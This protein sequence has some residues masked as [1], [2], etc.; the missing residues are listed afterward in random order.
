MSE[1]NKVKIRNIKSGAMDEYRIGGSSSD[2]VGATSSQKGEHGLVPAPKAG[3]QNKF[4]RGD[5]SWV[6]VSGGEGAVASVNGM[7]GTV[8]LGPS[9]VNAIPSDSKGTANGVAELDATGK[10][11]I[12]QIP[13]AIGKVY[14]APTVNDFPTIGD[15]ST[16]YISLLDN[17]VYRWGG[18]VYVEISEG[19]SLGTTS[20]TAHRGDH[21][22]VAYNHALAKGKQ[23]ATGFY[24]IQTN[25]EGHVSFVENVTKNDITS[26]GL[27]AQFQYET[28]PMASIDN[29]GLVIQYVGNNTDSFYNSH[30]YKCVKNNS[31][32]TWIDTY[33]EESMDDIDFTKF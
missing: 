2:M 4:F 26:L 22:V 8:I 21:G 28:M 3:D 15:E 33:E 19:V 6:E 17:K 12:S 10:V 9:D 13:G 31:Q 29:V 16:M 27:Q 24:K 11:P 5:G 14:E 30:F 7:T 32:Y 20:N 25:A 1:I 23:Y 18:S